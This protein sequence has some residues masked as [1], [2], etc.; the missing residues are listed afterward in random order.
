MKLPKL[1]IKTKGQLTDIDGR[2]VK[3]RIGKYV[4]LPQ[5]NYPEK[6]FILQEIFF[7]PG[8]MIPKKAKRKREI[9]IGYYILGKKPGMKGRWVWGQFC[10]LI[11]RNDLNKLLKKARKEKII[12]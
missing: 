10:P 12:I 3:F 2:K 5:S 1:K 7:E 4:I 8:T 11:S 9:R 6:V